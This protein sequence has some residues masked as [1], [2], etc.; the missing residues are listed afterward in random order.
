MLFRSSPFEFYEFGKPENVEVLPVSKKFDQIGPV[1]FDRLGK[2]LAFRVRVITEEVN[3]P[4]TIYKED[5]AVATGTIVTIPNV[6]K[7][8]EVMKLAKTIAGT[9][10]R[11]ELGPTTL[12]FNRY[13]LEMKVNI[14]G[15]DT[16]AKWIKIK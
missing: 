13:S 12:P 14:S 7:V 10:F 16:D 8:Y 3:L 6:D 11:I 5:T 4:Y 9:V 1:D 15:M 2:L